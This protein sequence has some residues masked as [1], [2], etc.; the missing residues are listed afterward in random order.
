MK[1][2]VL[3]KDIQNAVCEFLQAKG[4]FFWRSNNIPVF[5]RNNAG[6]MTFRSMGKYT[7]RG[8]PDIL[9]VHKGKFIG[10][11]IKRDKQSKLSE[12]QEIFRDNMAKNGAYYYT[13][14]S[15]DDLY[16]VPPLYLG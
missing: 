5:G 6:K 15:I 1:E 11:E 7:P 10:L 13:I 2:R 12:Y 16:R 9:V 4:Y 8:V 3:E 14:Y